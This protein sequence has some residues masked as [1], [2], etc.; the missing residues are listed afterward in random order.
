[1]ADATLSSSTASDHPHHPHYGHAQQTLPSFASSFRSEDYERPP[2]GIAQADWVR[3]ARGGGTG[4][5]NNNSSLD[6]GE[7]DSLKYVPPP[8]RVPSR[9]EGTGRAGAGAASLRQMTASPA[10]TATATNRSR[11]APPITLDSTNSTLDDGD[12]DE[13]GAGDR[14]ETTTHLRTGVNV[15]DLSSA[16]GGTSSRAGDESSSFA[17]VYGGG[18]GLTGGRVSKASAAG[19]GAMTLREQEKVIDELKKDNFSLKLKL[20]FYEQR[21]EKMAPSSVEQALRENIQLKV[22]FQTLRT[23]LK[24]YKKLLLDGDKA[25]QALT[26][27]RDSLAAAGG[28][29]GKSGAIVAQSAR[30]KE[31]ERRLMEQEEQREQWEQKARGLHKENKQMRSEGGG[32]AVE[33]L[34]RQLA[35]TEDEADLLKRQLD[36]AHDELDEVRRE[37]AEMRAELADQVDRSGVTEGR[38]VGLVRRE[39][40]KLEQDNDALR[41]E[42]AQREREKEALTRQVDELRTDLDVVAQELERERLQGARAAGGT[43]L[44]KELDSHRDRATS[45]ALEL[46]DVKTA[47]DAK[48]REIEELLAELDERDQVH[49]EELQKVADEWRDEAEEAKDREREARQALDE[50]EADV[51]GLADKVEELARR[52]AEK[53][54]DLQAEQEESAALIHDLKKLGAQIFQLEE[55]ADEKERELED[56]RRELEAVDKELE[57]K[58]EVHEQVVAGLKQKLADSKTHISDLTLQ[59]ESSTTELAFLRSKV[60]ELTKAHSR[61]EKQSKLG[62]SEKERLVRE[63]DEIMRA[64][65]KEEEER[66]MVEAQLGTVRNEVRRL[67]G[68]AQ[69]RERDVADL[70]H[71]LTGLE[72][73]GADASSDKIALELE[74][75]RVKRDLARA[76]EAEAR[77]RA[78]LDSRIADVREKDWRLAA[79]A[80]ENKDLSAQLASVRQAH[81]S[82]SDKHDETAK[83]LRDTQQELTSAR[84]RLRAV[85]SQLS[86]DQRA[87]SRTENQFR[88]Q[89]N[90][91]NTLLLTVYQAV[92]KVAGADKRKASTSEPPKPFANF[93]IFHDRLL[94]R[95]KGINQLHMSFERRTKELEER[96]VDQLQTLKRQQESRNSQVDRFEA[97]LKMALESQKQWRQRVQQKSLELEQAKFEVSSLQTQLASLRRSPNPNA[98]PDPSSPSRPA[99]TEAT[100]QARLRTAE[101]KVV[102]LERRLAATQEQLREAETRLSEQQKKY[103]VAEGKW[104]ARVRELEQRVRVA[105]EK[106]KRERQGAKERVA[107][108]EQDAR[109]LRDNIADAKRR[110]HQLDEVLRQAPPR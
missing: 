66:E 71:A 15:L 34:K 52:L 18:A 1:M 7:D 57:N 98:S 37:A 65:R 39:V 54:A 94:E 107:E 108:L 95:L 2:P 91:R 48:E 30:E 86:T 82:L 36:D 61:L 38:S 43:E 6:N 4:A 104:E 73:Q 17:N 9:G 88:D 70:Q 26:A 27:E 84:D 92:D 75:E 109:R 90:E 44:E 41:D 81:I 83:A 16:A 35:D 49:A 87:V 47:L 58:T 72:A 106:V 31:L 32:E 100:M 23:G 8:P 56:L 11:A 25:I 103:G 12:G 60:D 28:G 97:S 5:N 62:S 93:P 67:Q 53:E 21:L 63:A 89:L 19:G 102:T 24:R 64:L 77:N 74:V 105:E 29:R 20:H 50:K 55:E 40:D 96:F 14:T 33:E 110:D 69:D 80:S 42:L 76:Q 22:E 59:H 45:L 78:E 79:V 99:W 101:A 3:L 10:S 51:E 68:I 85:E 13:S 46:E